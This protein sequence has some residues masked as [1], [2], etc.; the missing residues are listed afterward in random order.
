A[1]LKA[2]NGLKAVELLRATAAVDSSLAVRCDLAVATV[3]AG[4][5]TAALAALKS[6]TG[7][8]CP[9]PPP[10]D[11]QAAPILAAFTEGLNP[12]RAG[13]PLDRL[14]ALG[15]K[16]SGPAAALLGTAIRVVALN[17][18]QD[19]YRNGQLPAARK[20]L[21]TARG[22]AARVGNDEVA[23]NLA[24]LDLADG[25]IDVAI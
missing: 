1:A 12:H 4:D 18:A 13:K 15:G 8:T 11:T 21:A 22:A 10:A 19:A 7:Q 20:Y 2:G 16:S 14:T 25:H 9:F 24:V 3:V 23:H 6:I 17:A 5:P